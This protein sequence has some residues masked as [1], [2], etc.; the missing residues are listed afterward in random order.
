MQIELVDAATEQETELS[1]LEMPPSPQKPKVGRPKKKQRMRR[2]T[3]PASSKQSENRSNTRTDY[4][5]EYKEFSRATSST[6]ESARIQ[7]RN[8]IAHRERYQMNRNPVTAES[9]LDTAIE[10][11]YAS[12]QREAFDLPPGD[13][14][15]PGFWT[16]KLSNEFVHYTARG[17]LFSGQ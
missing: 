3:S 6:E 1:G 16:E 4:F 9:N 7:E 8:T 2:A 10:Q 14:I 5:R 11:L 17:T 15:E 13:G 12:A